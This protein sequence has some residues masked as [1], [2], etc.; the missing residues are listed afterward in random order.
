M[1][2]NFKRRKWPRKASSS[3]IVLFCM[4]FCLTVVSHLVILLLVS[5][6]CSNVITVAAFRL[7]G[8]A[9]RT[10]TFRGHDS[11]VWVKIKPSGDHRF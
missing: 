2:V 5:P 3:M 10:E 6:E 4:L 1:W 7:D 9:W 11:W 8:L